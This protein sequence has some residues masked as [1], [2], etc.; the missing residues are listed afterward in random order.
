MKYLSEMKV[1]RNTEWLDLALKCRK[2]N[3]A[4]LKLIKHQVRKRYKKYNKEVKNRGEEP[5]KSLFSK[6]AG[7][8]PKKSKQL[9]SS[10]LLI[11]YYEKPPTKLG[12][13]IAHRRKE[14]GL[15]DCPFCGKPVAPDTLDHFIPKDYWPDYSIYPN[16]L[17]PQCRDCAPIKGKKYFS[18]NETI[19]ISPIFSDLLSKTYFKVSINF[20]E[21]KDDVS[22]SVDFVFNIENRQEILLVQRHLA[23]LKVE[24]RIED[25]CKAEYFRIIRKLRIRNFDL[26]LFLNNGLNGKYPYSDAWEDWEAAFCDSILNCANTMTYL[27][28]YNMDD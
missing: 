13:K 28:S 14:H 15:D 12:A 24:S 6:H 9:H 7:Y 1:N 22:F 23:S 11:N 16:N 21:I 5:S 17:V 18:N 10:D 8:D 27:N 3:V 20:N 19:F 25:Y 4:Q 26:G 2:A